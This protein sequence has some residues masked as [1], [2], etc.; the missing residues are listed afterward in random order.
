MLIVNKYLF[1][2]GYVE[3]KTVGNSDNFSLINY[4]INFRCCLENKQRRDA[5]FHTYTYLPTSY[6]IVIDY[7]L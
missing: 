4:G 2:Q 1:T 6:I 5:C 7:S 3:N